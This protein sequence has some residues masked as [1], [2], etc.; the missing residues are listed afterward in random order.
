MANQASTQS[1]QNRTSDGRAV[2]RQGEYLQP[3]LPFRQIDRM[4]DDFLSMF[5][6]PTRTDWQHIRMAAAV[7]PRMDVSETDTEIRVTADLP[8]IDDKDVEVNLVDDVLTIRGETKLDR[9]DKKENYH[10][11]ERARG[12]FARS[13]RL[14]FRVDPQQVQA[15]FKDGVLTITVPKPKE[16]RDQVQRI[17]VRREEGAA[18][19]Q[20]QS[21]SAQSNSS[22]K[23]AA[24]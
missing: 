1:S 17:E 24:E 11:M 3:L 5:G 22:E 14:P 4:F 21:Q 6:V 2:A 16:S 8:G 19:G 13:L 7:V 20:Q 9:E 10:V 15:S 18:T 23:A 12:S